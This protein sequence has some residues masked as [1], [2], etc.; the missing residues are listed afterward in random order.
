M[1]RLS[2]FILLVSIAPLAFA[3]DDALT[4]KASET[5]P[6]VKKEVNW[7]VTAFSVIDEKALV[8]LTDSNAQRILPLKPNPDA[9]GNKLIS[10]SFNTESN[11]VS[12]VAIIDGTQQ[13]ITSKLKVPP[14]KPRSPSDEDR[15]KYE[16]LSD[17][18]KEK[19]REA[20]RAKFE[21]PAFRNFSEEERRNAMRDIFEKIQAED[22]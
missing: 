10:A 14:S 9:Q 21:N 16:S 12:V 11:N 7:K 19:L 17:K 6:V 13:S 2:L 3:A 5:T 18:G 15:K 20:F 1:L 22:K 8:V 4:P